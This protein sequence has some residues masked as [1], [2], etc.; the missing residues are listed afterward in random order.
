MKLHTTIVGVKYPA[1]PAI[2]NGRT[3][4]GQARKSLAC[5]LVACF[6]AFFPFAAQTA[7]VN[8]NRFLFLIDTSVS[9]K[10]FDKALR[11]NVFDL[12]YSGVRGQMTNG[13]TYGI[14]LVTD[15]TDTSF[16]MESWG[17]RYGVELGGKATAHVKKQG[18]KSKARLD[19]AFADVMRVVRNVGDLTIILVS[20]GET[21]I[22]GTPFDDAVNERFR[23]LV[24]EMKRTKATLNTAFVARDG[25]IVAWA[26]NTPELLVSVPFVPRKP[27]PAVALEKT[28]AS[29]NPSNSIQKA[30][31]SH[32][33]PSTNAEPPKPRVTPKPIIITKETVAEERRTYQGLT[34]IGNTNEPATPTAGTN[35]IASGTN[36]VTTNI[37]AAL[38][39]NVM[40][41]SVPT[42]VA[43][44][45]N[46]VLGRTIGST[47]FANANRFPTNVIT[48]QTKI[49]SPA[50]AVAID[51]Q[52]K[53]PVELTS[54][55]RRI[56]PA[57][58]VAIGAS[59][60][61]LA[62]LAI[63]LISR[64]RGREPSL[65]SQTM[66]LETSHSPKS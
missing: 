27:K 33:M 43:T 40:E 8:A 61:L 28:N 1:R 63:G 26:A 18:Y 31:V 17:Q 7:E 9:M 62:V 55:S 47:D 15:Q 36:L 3:Q 45:T 54:G 44:T 24:P 52:A 11:E 64:S 19:I 56:H 35:A 53:T 65:I 59:T 2:S 29:P 12:V 39:M 30:I 22:A 58:W 42:T 5:V 41:K 32:P 37:A 14:W 20:N 10:P 16:S 50:P 21:P 51:A 48:A 6:A 13:D 49:E 60:A 23:Q 66:G 4:L 57:L 34:M 25:E 46:A 38:V